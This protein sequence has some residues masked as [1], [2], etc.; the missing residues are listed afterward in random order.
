VTSRRHNYR[1][2]RRGVGVQIGGTAAPAATT[3]ATI[4]GVKC[5]EYWRSDLGITIGTGVSAWAGQVLGLNFT[6]AVA[7]S[8][9][10]Y[11]ATGGANSQPSLLAD[12]VDDFMDCDLL[13]RAQPQTV[14]LVARQTGWSIN[15]SIIN[16]ANA[17][18]IIFQ[19]T[20][21]PT[22]AQSSGVVANSNNGAAVNT[23]KRIQGEFQNTAADRLLIGT[24][25][26]TGAAAGATNGTRPLLARNAGS[27]TFGAAEYCEIILVSG[28]PSA[29]E[30]TALNTYFTDRY[31]AAVVA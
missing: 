12:G 27:T 25:N 18:L 1:N 2:N 30:N 14:I 22:L 3:P 26:T 7:G 24:T 16:D 10:A 20:A 19:R 21:T 6:Q 11:N 13:A 8:Q 9:F 15:E 17:G 5:T 29:G 31:G 23:Y 4:L 28:I